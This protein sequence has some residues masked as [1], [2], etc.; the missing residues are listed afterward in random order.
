MQLRTDRTQDVAAVQLRRR[1]KIEC[2]GEE[3]DPSRAADRVKEKR[4]RRDS[5]AKYSGEKSQQQ[6]RS[7]NNFGVIGVREARDN[8]R[9]ED[10]VYQRGR[11]KEEA[12]NGAGGADIEQG[13][14][15]S[16]RRTDQDKRSESADE[17]G[18][19]NEKRVARANMVM[20]AGEE[21]AEL[22]REKDREQRQGKGKARGEACRILVEKRERPKEFVKRSCIVLRVRLR[23]LRSG[24]ETGAKR[25]KK[26]HACQ[27]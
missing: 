9:V 23:K 4:G 18:K 3:S 16:N 27:D 24:D 14:G 7:E 8:S 6:R 22:V 2:R 12:Y 1:Q 15:R 20:A 11:C 5:R 13:A 25:K 19:R 26:Q 21:V 17:R 10:A